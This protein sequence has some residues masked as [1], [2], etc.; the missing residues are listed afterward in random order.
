ML[1]SGIHPEGGRQGSVGVCVEQCVGSAGSWL[2][3]GAETS[4][5][6]PALCLCRGRL[7]EF[8]AEFP[9]GWKQ[10]D[11]VP[12]CTSRS[13]ELLLERCGSCCFHCCEHQQGEH[14]P[15]VSC[16]GFAACFGGT[17]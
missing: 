6:S 15:A 7:E 3:P 5:E 4:S 11:S 1:E 13:A 17:G 2:V 12:A 10:G 8:S 9:S 16:D 14:D